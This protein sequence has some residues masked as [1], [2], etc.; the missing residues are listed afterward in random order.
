MHPQFPLLSK[1]A[2]LQKLVA[3]T[4]EE[5]SDE[6]YIQ[7]IPGGPAAFE[8]CAKYCYGMTVTLNAYNVVAARCAA[9]Y[10]EMHE[11]VEKGNLIYKIDVFL[12][13][14]IFKSWKDSIIVLQ[15][16]RSLLPWSEELKI[17]SH[18][19]DSIASKV[20][21]DTSRVEWSYTYN[22]KKLPSENGNDPNWNG[23]RKHHNV[24]KDWWVEDLCELPV[25]LY[26]RV[27]TTIK[28]RGKIS[29]DVIGEALHAYAFRR[30]PGF[31]KGINQGCDV[32]KY[33]SLAETL[34]WL[35]PSEKGSI[36]CSFL[37]KLL[38]AVI[39][40]G[41][42]EKEQKELMRKISEQL[43]EATVGDLLISS[44]SETTMYD[45]DIVQQLV[46]EF[47]AQA[48]KDHVDPGVDH[49][50]QEI[51]N[52]SIISDTSKMMVAKLVDG[53]LAEVARDP[54]LPLAKFANLA[55]MVSGFPRP[56]HDGIYRAI[57]M[58]LK[59]ISWRL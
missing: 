6:L 13:S 49:E 40:L 58:F 47:V 24:P 46:E 41:C 9:E 7:D 2:C 42:R 20:S 26:K 4:N 53:Y 55:E 45:V 14:S 57:D 36:S 30:L 17:V 50:Y 1:S 15:T 34:V 3:T 18:G 48:Q 25:D 10:L 5:N 59:V 32:S 33:R 28:A 11:T 35:L 38:R 19:L 44:T 27:I 43:D 51:A 56:S 12:N 31:G 29:G 23:V 39:L 21:I 22:R 8:I 52:P 54:K 37:L 16:A